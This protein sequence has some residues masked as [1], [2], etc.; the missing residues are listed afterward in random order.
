MDPRLL[1]V[2]CS[3]VTYALVAAI[4][5][6]FTQ[7][8]LAPLK[9]SEGLLYAVPY[10]Y[11]A[12]SSSSFPNLWSITNPDDDSC[13]M[14]AYIEENGLWGNLTTFCNCGIMTTFFNITNESGVAVTNVEMG[15]FEGK[16]NTPD[17]FAMAPHELWTWCTNASCI[18]WKCH[19]FISHQEE[20][21]I[22]PIRSRDGNLSDSMDTISLSSLK[23]E[24][25]IRIIGKRL[26]DNKMNNFCDPPTQKPSGFSF[27]ILLIFE[28]LF[29][30]SM[31]A[32]GGLTILQR[33]QQYSRQNNV[34][35]K[36]ESFRQGPKTYQI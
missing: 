1:A 18:I 8:P 20:S 30:T 35:P 29:G 9:T 28:I 13:I 17:S 6:P 11:E 4:Q 31:M 2:W 34:H 19:E 27:P 12:V 10:E 21:A 3:T 24:D 36:I 7:C 14:E 33:L 22:L 23:P 15:Q 5:F 16:P 25:F 26:D 32:Y